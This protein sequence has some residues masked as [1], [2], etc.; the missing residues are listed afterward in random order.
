MPNL[1]RFPPEITTYVVDCGNRDAKS[2]AIFCRVNR[3]WIIRL[4]GFKHV[5]ILV[6]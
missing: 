2:L 4:D 5:I 3:Q 6:K 1:A